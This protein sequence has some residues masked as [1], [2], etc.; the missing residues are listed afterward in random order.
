MEELQDHLDAEGFEGGTEK[1][2]QK[3]KYLRVLLSKMTK[4]AGNELP[5]EDFKEMDFSAVE[6]A[7]SLIGKSTSGARG[8]KGLKGE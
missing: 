7:I 5:A 1:A 2:L 8:G 6:S 3:M 4:F